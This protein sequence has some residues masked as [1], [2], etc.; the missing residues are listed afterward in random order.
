MPLSYNEQMDKEN[1]L[2]LR[3]LCK[4]LPPYC[5]DF[6][7]GIEPR[8]ESKT[9]IAYAY[10]LKV[11]FS[12]LL[13]SNP[14]L[15]A[16]YG[17]IQALPLAVLDRLSGD[18][19]EEY[20]EY[21]KYRSEDN[22]EIFNKERGIKRKIASLKSFYKYFYDKE[23]LE[24]N[25]LSRVPLPRLKD[26][27]IVRLEIDEVVRFL[28]EVEKGDNLSDRQKAYH[29]KNK[30]RDL[31]LLTLMLGTGIRVSECVGI[32]IGDIDLQTSGI[33]I[34]RKGGKEQRI[35]FGEE[36]EQALLDYLAFRKG[37]IPQ[38]GHEDA[39]FLSLQLRRISVRSVENLVKKY[40]S[41]V[42][43]LKTITPH[44]LRSTYGT[45][46]YKETDDI[47][48]VASVLGHSDVN[49]TKKHYAALED[50]RRRQARNAVKLRRI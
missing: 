14:V 2:K 15:A 48:L 29:Q 13:E 1:I 19:I 11:F 25:P 34:H 4:D 45:N 10:D 6:F 30:I 7:R 31:A 8:T 33:R 38:A 21:L 22:K 49:T 37:Q 35:Y 12:Y 46:L 26:K 3:E 28:D 47:Y 50:D 36:V 32:N 27:E 18:D 41:R 16:E 40:A 42:T 5:K 9:R 44:K 23:A 43:P 24:N 39:L 20:M 17:C